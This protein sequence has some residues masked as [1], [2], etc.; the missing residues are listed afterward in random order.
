MTSG[1]LADVNVLLAALNRDHRHHHRAQEWLRSVP[2]FVTTPITEAGLVRLLMNQ[3]VMND[4]ATMD[5]A[6]AA[7][8]AL[9]ERRNATFL[10]DS[11]SLADSRAITRH[12]TGTKQVTDTHL[13]NLAIA[14]GHVLTTFDRALRDSL[15]TRHR[16]YVRVLEA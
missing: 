2:L 16:H 13:L 10:P 4:P 7:L 12:V 11:T 9:R 5:R 15:P 14:S 6:V 1:E 3:A 8:R